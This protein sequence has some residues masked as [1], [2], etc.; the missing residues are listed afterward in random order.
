MGI[1]AWSVSIGIVTSCGRF[2]N[3]VAEKGVEGIGGP[4]READQAEEG[5][6]V[7]SAYAV[8]CTLEVMEE[9]MVWL[10]GLEPRVEGVINLLNAFLLD[11]LARDKGAL[12]LLRR[13]SQAGRDQGSKDIRN[14]PVVLVGD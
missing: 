14:D 3:D 5:D 8:V 4:G 13:L 10:V 11:A 9:E 7:V 12:H 2:G 1:L 6:E